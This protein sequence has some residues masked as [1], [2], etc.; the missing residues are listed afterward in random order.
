MNKCSQCSSQIRFYG[1]CNCQENDGFS[2]LAITSIIILLCSFF[3]IVSQW[4]IFGY[5]DYSNKS[6]ATSII[7]DKES[8]FI[9][10]F[11]NKVRNNPN[12]D[13]TGWK[14]EVVNN[15][16]LVT[17]HYTALTDKSKAPERRAYFWCVNMNDKEVHRLK[18]LKQFVDEYLLPSET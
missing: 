16:G 13:I 14:C 3:Y 10:N 6:R 1:Y 4:F 9:D 7:Q 18:S 8:S 2:F 15:W 11:E 17:Y 12:L 5:G